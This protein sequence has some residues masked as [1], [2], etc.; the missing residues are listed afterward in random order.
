MTAPMGSAAGVQLTIANA[1][2]A[3]NKTVRAAAF[4]A[5]R[6][7]KLS[8]ARS[9]MVFMSRYLKMRTRIMIRRMVP[10]PIYM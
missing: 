1:V 6:M 5:C 10:P 9:G 7:E 3:H 2:P 8:A 4:I